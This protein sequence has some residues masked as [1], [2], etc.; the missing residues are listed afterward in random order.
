M[1]K[2]RLRCDVCRR[3]FQLRLQ[4]TPVDM[5]GARQWFECPHCGH[6]YEVAVISALGLEIRERMQTAPVEELETLRAAMANE[7]SKPPS[8]A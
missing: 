3:R 2:K 4:E 1:A 5:G 7:V 8:A 6:V